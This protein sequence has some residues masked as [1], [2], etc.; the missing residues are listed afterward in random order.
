[1]AHTPEE[2]ILSE[3]REAILAEIRTALRR[4]RLTPQERNQLEARIVTPPQH[5]RPQFDDDLVRR[6][7]TKL[8]A[9]DA[10]VTSVK[11]MADVGAA[12]SAY[13][14]GLGVQPRIAAAPALADLQWPAWLELYFGKARPDEQ[15]AV[16]SCLA[17]VAETGSLVLLSGPE[18]PTTLNFV[19][20]NHVIVIRSQQIV[21][22]FEDVWPMLRALPTGMPRTV[23]IIAGPSRTA[24]VEQ[25]IQL[26]AHG[27]RRLHVVLVG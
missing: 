4:D 3:A 19:P 13:I 26:G 11:T 8:T 27:P 6:F 15:V 20:E 10:T 2:I 7:V 12:L 22:H 16:T 5:T 9:R 17:G 21:R 18:T 14:A 1:M 23:N 25:T 24:D